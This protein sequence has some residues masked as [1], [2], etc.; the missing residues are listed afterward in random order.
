MRSIFSAVALSLVLSHSVLASEA[1]PHGD[2]DAGK[3]L[4][5]TCASC[6]GPD[7]NSPAPSFPKI[8]GQPAGYIAKQ[9][10]AFQNK[11]RN[12]AV[13]M[14]MVGNLSD[15]DMLDL[16]AYYSRQ[17]ATSN[18]ISADQAAAATAGQTIYQTGVAE[19]SVTACTACHG[20]SGEGMAPS[21]PR[22]AGQHAAYIKSQLNAFKSG[23]RQ[24]VMMNSISFTLSEEQVD[25]LATYLSALK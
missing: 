6:H 1:A 14:G 3:A 8:A 24:N 12:N 5:A 22:L 9:L 20:P 10:A 13:M 23:D 18:A 19:F 16:D 4:S 11:T 7:G 15:Q 21:F 2:A 17:A 25:Q